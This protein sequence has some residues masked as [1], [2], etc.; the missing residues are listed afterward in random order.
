VGIEF[1]W[2]NDF[3]ESLEIC[4]INCKLVPH[5][6][7]T[8]INAVDLGVTINCISLLNPYQPDELLSVQN[9]F[10]TQGSVF[11]QLWEDI[12]LTKGNQVL[13]RIKS[14]AGQ[15]KR[16]YARKT[17]VVQLTKP[18]AEAFLNT[19]HLQGSVLARY[20]FGLIVSD[21]LVAVATF[22]GTRLMKNKSL[23]YRSAEL[24]RFA[25]KGG[26]TVTGG[27]SKL[28]K[29]FVALVKTNDIM[30]YADRDW[31]TGKGYEA[32]GFTFN[33]LVPPSDIWVDRIT[34][35]RYFSHRLPK[36]AVDDYV[37]DFVSEQRFLKIF[38]TGNLKY[39]LY[40]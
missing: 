8:L 33:S 39:I 23:D 24:I 29:H 10:T 9:I 25:T 31:S 2:T 15:N 30:S 32:A 40:L 14:L 12:W 34:Q 37:D 26:Y 27:M 18:A 3:L 16:L 36:N 17:K 21:E 1:N 38:N 4:G 13:N 19:H 5:P 28:I 35:K 6:R 22:S 11:V 20:K 7:F